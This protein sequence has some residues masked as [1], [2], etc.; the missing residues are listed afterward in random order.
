MIADYGRFLFVREPLSQQTLLERLAKL[1]QLKFQIADHTV[2]STT[3][4]GFSD[5]LEPSKT[6]PVPPC[7]I[8]EIYFGNTQLSSEPL[9][10]PNPQSRTIEPVCSPTVREPST[11]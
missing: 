10:H 3:G 8:F 9:L 2:T 7:T 11:R 5:R 1:S 4:I 6:G